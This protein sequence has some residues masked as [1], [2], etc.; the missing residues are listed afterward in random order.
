MIVAE[1]ETDTL[2][3]MEGRGVRHAVGVAEPVRRDAPERVTVALA[4]AERLPFP[5]LEAVA[6]TDAERVEDFD[7]VALARDVPVFELVVVADV[8]AVALIELVARAETV[9]VRLLEVVLD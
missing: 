7:P 6:L 3:V 5:E 2:I 4:E 8:V 9:V 1:V